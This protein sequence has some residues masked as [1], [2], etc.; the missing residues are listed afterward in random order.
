M[1]EKDGVK[2]KDKEDDWRPVQ[3]KKGKKKEKKETRDEKRAKKTSK[4]KKRNSGQN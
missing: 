4:T 1:A 2:A 3:L